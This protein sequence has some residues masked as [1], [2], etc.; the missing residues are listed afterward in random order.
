MKRII[1]TGIALLLGAVAGCGSSDKC[2]NV[3]CGAAESCNATSG[4][5]ENKCATTTC[6]GGQTC[7]SAVGMCANP[8]APQ[9]AALPLI[10]RMG[11]PAVNTALTNPFDY[12][13]PQGGTA[14]LS[15]VTKDRYNIDGNPAAWSNNW[16]AAVKLHL[17]IFDALDDA[18]GDQIAY[19]ALTLPNY[20]ALASILA[21]DALNVDTT[22]TTC[23]MYLGAEVGAL[24]TAT[25]CG[26]RKLDYDVIDATYAALAGAP[27]F[28]DTIAQNTAPAATFPFMANP[29]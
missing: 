3:T 10:D 19:G 1:F 5:C 4:A 2:A 6:S 25:D 27:G 11:R 18:C 24:S 28:G 8:T 14:E 22:K 15:D 29:R 23:A 26:G 13:A 9:T 16:G 20:T 17:G 7:D 12:Y 21:G